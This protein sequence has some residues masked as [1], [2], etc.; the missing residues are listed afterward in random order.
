MMNRTYQ[1]LLKRYPK[2]SKMSPDAS[3]RHC[4]EPSTVSNKFDI[5]ISKNI[6]CIFKLFIL[7]LPLFSQMLN[8][9]LSKNLCRKLPLS[10]IF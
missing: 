7:F 5:F 6:L 1:R 8:A 2:I 4:A 9:Q 10:H 3:G